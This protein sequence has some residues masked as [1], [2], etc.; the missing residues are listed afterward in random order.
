MDLIRDNVNSLRDSIQ[1]NNLSDTTVID[2]FTAFYMI[3]SKHVDYS[4]TDDKYFQ[5]LIGC[6]AN[7]PR[8]HEREYWFNNMFSIYEQLSGLTTTDPHWN[9]WMLLK[10][11][12]IYLSPR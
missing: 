1:R 9:D 4:I 6:I 7:I 10:A 5:F 3:T 12:L 11:N 8:G 2:V